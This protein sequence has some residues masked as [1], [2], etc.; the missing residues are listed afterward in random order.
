MKRRNFKEA[1]AAA[2]CVPVVAAKAIAC[3]N[4]NHLIREKE[5]VF[6]SDWGK[7]KV[8]STQ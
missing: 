5:V 6:E 2:R 1:F 7:V 8:K 4:G 3:G